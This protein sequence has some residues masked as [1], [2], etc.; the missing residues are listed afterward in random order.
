MRAQDHFQ[1]GRL[2]EAIAAATAEVKAHPTDTARRGFLAELLCFTGAIERADLQLEALAHQD[3]GSAIGVALFR[4]V[5][6]GEQARQQVFGEGRLPEFLAP[7]PEPVRLHL[8]ALTALR[9]GDVVEAGRLLAVVEE[10]RVPLTG[11]CDG[12]AFADFRDLDD[13]TAAVFEVITSSG[14]YFWVPCASVVSIDVRPPQRPRDL[15]WRRAAMTVADGPD[16]EVFLPALYPAAPGEDL[17]TPLRLGRATDW[18]GGEDSPVR[19]VGQRMLLV[20]DEAVPIMSVTS[21]SF[22]A[23]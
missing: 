17:D 7:P 4:Q 14:K 16:G 9:G 12:R 10:M 13:V 18:R 3:P 2:A 1:A 6:R 20:G 5:L 21:L 23:D 8:A 19:G 11:H 22:G 15:I